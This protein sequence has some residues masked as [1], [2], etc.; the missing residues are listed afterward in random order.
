MNHKTFFFQILIVDSF[1][2]LINIEI[3]LAVNFF[4]INFILFS[5]FIFIENDTLLSVTWTEFH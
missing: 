1:V 4:R 3:T 2:I 5:D